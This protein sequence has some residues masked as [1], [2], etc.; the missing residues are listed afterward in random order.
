MFWLGHKRD[1][2][3][4]H[5]AVELYLSTMRS[6]NTG[7]Q[8]KGI[9]REWLEFL[10]SPTVCSHSSP[11]HSSEAHTRAFYFLTLQ[12]PSARA[13]KDPALPETVTPFTAYRKI[14]AL[15]SIYD[16]LIA[17][18]VM[19]ENPFGRLAKELTHPGTGDRHPTE[20]LTVAEVRRILSACQ[21]GRPK[22]IVELG[23]MA[24]LFGGALRISEVI[25]LKVEDCQGSELVL[26]ATKS[27]RIERQE[28][29]P[30]AVKA[31]GSLQQLRY[32]QGAGAMDPLLCRV[33]AEGRCH[34]LSLSG[35]RRMFVKILDR[36]GV[37]R[38]GT[39]SGRATA[40]TTLLSSGL[41]HREVQEFSRHASIQM[42]ERYDKR[43][44]DRKRI[45][46]SVSY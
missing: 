31:F 9:W 19:P 43:R 37:R 4:C 13:I 26:R 30:W 3:G 29:P 6:R 27:G 23:L 2:K 33:N 17:V 35:A 24:G 28:L 7:R 39:H 44:F 25:G 45:A 32:S 10:A 21:G 12:R 15:K 46:M 22:E 18:G 1:C 14:V 36:A 20:A 11:C 40:I 8:Y 42:V 41:S 16:H 5:A 38:V 34:R